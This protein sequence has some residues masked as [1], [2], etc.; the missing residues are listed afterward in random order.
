MAE[1]I[2]YPNASKGG[3]TSVIRGRAV[4]EPRK[5]FD[6]VFFHDKGGRRAFSDLSNVR[7]TIIRRDRADFAVEYLINQNNYETVS[8]LSSP[9][10]VGHIANAADNIRYEFHSSNPL[11]IKS[12]LESMDLNQVEEFAVPS[13]FLRGTVAPLLPKF[14]RRKLRVLPNVV[15]SSIFTPEGATD[16][17]SPSREPE[18]AAVPLVWVGRFDT[19]K[20]YRHF[21]R[22]LAAL[23]PRYFGIVVVSFESDPSRAADFYHECAAMGVT[24][25]VQL[26]LNQSQHE[27]AKLYRWAKQR[28]GLAVSTSLLESFGYFVAEAT[29]CELPVV[30]FELPV[31]N[32]QPNVDMIST[33]PIGSVT[34]LVDSIQWH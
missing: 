33:V 2:V 18:T 24:D 11:V 3:I 21:L 34:A 28:G 32:E 23:P 7:T 12:E 1:L 4:E 8:V 30:A 25:R 17:Y 15:D 31:F 16:F 5:R 19:G 13:K 14:H 20:G 6:V 26:Y 27:M 22:A 10:T 9:K 29:A